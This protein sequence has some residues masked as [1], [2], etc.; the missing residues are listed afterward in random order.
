MIALLSLK[1]CQ[2][3]RRKCPWGASREES[4]L[5]IP[6]ERRT[7]QYGVFSDPTRRAEPIFHPAALSLAYVE[8][9]HLIRDASLDKKWVSAARSYV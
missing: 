6:N 4:G 7:T 9:L 1:K 2:A 5:V 3:P 8:Q